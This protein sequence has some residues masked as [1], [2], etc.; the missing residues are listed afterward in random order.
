MINV[1]VKEH[2]VEEAWLLS[3]RDKES[4]AKEGGEDGGIEV[5]GV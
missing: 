2:E 1:I 3:V 4:G 5:T